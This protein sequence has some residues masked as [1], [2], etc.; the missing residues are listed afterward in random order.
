MIRCWKFSIW[1]HLLPF[2]LRHNRL[3][4]ARQPTHE[5][6]SAGLERRSHSYQFQGLLRTFTHCRI[7]RRGQDNRVSHLTIYDTPPYFLYVIFFSVNWE[8]ERRLR[9]V[10]GFCMSR[11]FFFHAGLGFGCSIHVLRRGQLWNFD[12]RRS[13][14]RIFS[15]GNR[16]VEARRGRIRTLR[17]RRGRLVQRFGHEKGNR[18]GAYVLFHR[19]GGARF[20]F[21]QFVFQ[22][23]NKQ[24]QRHHN[25]NNTT[26]ITITPP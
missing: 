8:T 24:Q 2:G 9:Q 15:V 16:Q 6:R 3:L 10:Y 12:D 18:R 1:S 25:N 7:L 4:S 17:N 13:G 22:I 21:P 26:I 23:V 20:R 19:R 5:E 11:Y 14:R